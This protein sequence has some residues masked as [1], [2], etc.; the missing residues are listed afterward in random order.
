MGRELY[1]LVCFFFFFDINHT[2]FYFSYIPICGR[3]GKNA[4]RKEFNGTALERI[5]ALCFFFS[6]DGLRGAGYF[7][8]TY[9]LLLLLLLYWNGPP[10]CHHRLGE[11]E[12][13]P[14]SGRAWGIL[15][16]TKKSGRK[17]GEEKKNDWGLSLYFFS[18]R[19]FGIFCF[20]IFFI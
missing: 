17:T 19:S 9:L 6:L 15:S 13:E 1:D 20:V 10:P 3:S 5:L 2:L 16:K 11:R 14:G 8:T 7:L 18:S 4:R 12:T